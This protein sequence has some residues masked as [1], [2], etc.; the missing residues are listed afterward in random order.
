L[1]AFLLFKVLHQVINITCL[2]LKDVL[3]AVQDGNF[4]LNFIKLLFH[5]L[6]CVIFDAKGCCILSKVILLHELLALIALVL[7]LL[8]TQLL[9]QSL[10]LDFKLFHFLVLLLLFLGNAVGLR[11]IHCKIVVCG[12]ILL[13][14]LLEIVDFTLETFRIVSETLKFRL[15]GGWLL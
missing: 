11:F 14:F 13:N 5:S 8:F 4:R 10:L 3:G 6:E 2:L 1:N 15:A 7:L 12:R 9:L